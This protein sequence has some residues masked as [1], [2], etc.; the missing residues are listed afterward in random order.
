MS[1]FY[2]TFFCK[3]LIELAQKEFEADQKWCGN[4]HQQNAILEYDNQELE[5]EELETTLQIGGFDQVQR[6]F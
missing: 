6:F 4:N 3:Q 2:S 5:L 1:K